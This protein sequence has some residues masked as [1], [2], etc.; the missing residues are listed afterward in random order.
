MPGMRRK[1]PSGIRNREDEKITDAAVAL[2]NR[3]AAWRLVPGK[4]SARLDAEL[5]STRA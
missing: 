1:I 5:M 4:N 2:R 3:P